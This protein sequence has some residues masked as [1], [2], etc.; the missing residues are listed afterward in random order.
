MQRKKKSLATLGVLSRNDLGYGRPGVALFILIATLT[1]ASG[2]AGLAHI[3]SGMCSSRLSRC[4]LAAP[5]SHGRACAVQNAE[6]DGFSMGAGPRT[7]IQRKLFESPA[8][9]FHC[10][11][12]SSGTMGRTCFSPFRITV[13]DE[14][15]PTCFSVRTRCS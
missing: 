2:A 7:N 12:D 9:R 4:R 13:S 6:C 15:K 10:T 8:R 5:Y 1:W 11:L 3:R 14:R